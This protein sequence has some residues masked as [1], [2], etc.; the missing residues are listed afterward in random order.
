MNPYFGFGF[1]IAFAAQ[2]VLIWRWSFLSFWTSF[3]VSHSLALISYLHRDCFDC[4]FAMKVFSITLLLIYL[5][6][7]GV[8]ETWSF[9]GIVFMIFS[10][11]FIVVRWIMEGRV[12]DPKRRS[13]LE[14]IP[15][16]LTLLWV[17][18]VLRAT[19]T[20][21]TKTHGQSITACQLKGRRG[22]DRARWLVLC[23]CEEAGKR[24]TKV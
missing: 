13:L 24:R 17:W 16:Q 14:E 6:F 8:F 20:L 11:I 19:S 23:S 4:R 1:L 18:L 12:Q 22:W 10:D 7:F 21:T 15:C 2:L 3:P 5:I 9:Q